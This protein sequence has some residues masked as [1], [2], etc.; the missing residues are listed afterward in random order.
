MLRVCGQ[1][2]ARRTRNCCHFL[3]PQEATELVAG[4]SL[5][6]HAPP[7][8]TDGDS[9]QSLLEFPTSFTPD[10]L[11]SFAQHFLCPA[12][13]PSTAEQAPQFETQGAWIKGVRVAMYLGHEKL[14]DLTKFLWEHQRRKCG[15][16][17]VRSCMQSLL[18][19]HEMAQVLSLTE[20]DDF[21]LMVWDANPEWAPRETPKRISVAEF[22]EMPT[23]ARAALKRAIT[24]NKDPLSIVT[25]SV[26]VDHGVIAGGP[27]AGLAGAT[28][29]IQQFAAYMG[30]SLKPI[31]WQVMDL[32]IMSATG[33][34]LNTATYLQL[35]WSLFHVLPVKII[36]VHSRECSII[37]AKH[38]QRITSG[39]SL[40]EALH[41]VQATWTKRIVLSAI[42]LDEYGAAMTKG[43][44]KP[45]R[46]ASALVPALNVPTMLTCCRTTCH[47]A[48]N[49]VAYFLMFS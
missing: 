41:C 35:T 20:R 49:V 36:C 1:Q 44:L 32:E 15:P 22:F 9:A 34:R 11:Q 10:E 16:L 31:C 29:A 23:D 33:Q 2:G 7:L 25:T 30:S 8:P 21:A 17:G 19:S 14:G 12:W 37:A 46:A 48:C 13:P 38:S 43:F 27:E 28:N 39:E 40:T 4:C 18:C 45:V 3:S 5:L 6:R 42:S 26:H 47:L 24:R